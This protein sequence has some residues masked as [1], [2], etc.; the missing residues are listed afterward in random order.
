MVTLIFLQEWVSIG[1]LPIVKRITVV[2]VNYYS[3]A[4]IQR[5]EA[6]IGSIPDAFLVVVDNSADFIATSAQTLIVSPGCNLG[7]GKACNLG[8]LHAE[9][10][11][12][13]FLNPDALV[14][15]E[16]IHGLIT[17]APVQDSAIWA[18]AIEDHSGKAPTLSLPGRFGL[19][20]RRGYLPENLVD[21]T[22]IPVHYVSG[23]CMMMRTRFFRQLGGFCPEIFL[24]AEDLELCCR[25]VEMGA[26]ILVLSDLRVAHAGGQSSS[27]WISK[28]LRFSRS[29]AG[30]YTFFRKRTNPLSA[31]INAVH[32]ASGL[33]V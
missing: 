13:F 16:T 8:A 17:R 28:F 7:F 33:R 5:M 18:P 11:F 1:R 32:L 30:H 23:A 6:M 12:L 15:P 2:T 27:C 24:Y 3:T 22:R 26:D 31:A 25:A 29:W 10:E 19:I 9:T 21:L 4:L 14:T 20:Y